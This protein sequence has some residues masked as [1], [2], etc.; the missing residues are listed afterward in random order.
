MI[1]LTNTSD[2]GF[3]VFKR[4]FRLRSGIDLEHYTDVALRRCIAL[5]T[6]GVGHDPKRLKQ[7]IAARQICVQTCLRTMIPKVTYLFRDPEEWEHL[8]AFISWRIQCFPRPLRVWSAGCSYGAEAYSLTMLL[9]D[10]APHYNHYIVGTDID[11][12]AIRASIEGIFS[13]EEADT[14]SA[15]YGVRYLSAR[16]NDHQVIARLRRQVVFEQH[17]LLRDPIKSDMDVVA[18]RNVLTYLN[19]DAQ[20]QMFDRFYASLMPGGM[21]F[22][23]LDDPVPPSPIFLQLSRCIYMRLPGPAQ[24]ST[25]SGPDFIQ[26]IV[27]YVQ[28]C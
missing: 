19:K 13:T 10:L 27:K 2:A 9:D 16:G 28:I 5:A 7:Q 1:Q 15:K 4:W 3:A 25:L 11:D 24:S 18:C 14:I 26:F 22:I 20:T 8:H 12:N 6:H 23:G 21:L 17:N